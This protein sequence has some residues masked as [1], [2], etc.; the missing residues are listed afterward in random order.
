MILLSLNKKN[1]YNG[2][3]I[4]SPVDHIVVAHCRRFLCV[5]ELAVLARD[6]VDSLPCHFTLVGSVAEW[7]RVLVL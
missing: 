5:H 3:H 4:K 7:F 6:R 1:A 2:D